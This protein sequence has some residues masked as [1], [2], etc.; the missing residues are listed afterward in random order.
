MADLIAS[1][2]IKRVQVTALALLMISGAIN[3]V[4]RATLA[5]GMPLI[6][7][8]LGLSLTQSGVLLSAF[9]WTYAVSQLPAGVMIDRW[10][11]RIMLSVGLGLWSLAQVLGGLVHN[12]TQFIGARV[13]LGMGESAQFP[14][15]A[16]VVADWFH[17]RERGLATGFWNS[18]SSLGSAI[19]LPLLT[20]LMLNFGWR[21]MFAI[22]GIAGLVVA[23]AIY[24]LHRNP[25]EVELTPPEREYLADGLPKASKVTWGDWGRLFCFPTTW[26]MIGGYF[27]AMYVLWIYTAWLPQYLELELHVTVAKT[28]WIASIPYICGVVGSL[29]TGRICDLL[30]RSGFSPIASRKIPLVIAMFGVALLT[31]LTA[32]TSNVTLAI[33]YISG[34]LFLLYSIACAAWTMATVVA[35]SRYT[36]SLSTIQNFFGY[37]GAALAPI[38]TGWIAQETGSF[39][40][41]LLVG[42]ALVLTGAIIHLVLV[43]K[44]VVVGAA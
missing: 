38:A 19:A 42:A 3:Y 24:W 29:V 1:N 4:D 12:F 32:N 10:G 2:R 34:T 22:M 8:E 14:S 28:G 31:L 16:R 39:R 6:R 27:G 26:G 21:W 7:P 25:A 41:A 44:P 43:R 18:S 20:F 17:P 15:C 35:P 23:I 5:V 36:A 11:A 40:N 30:L 13:L 37:L 33:T 9:L